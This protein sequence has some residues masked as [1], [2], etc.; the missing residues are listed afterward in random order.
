MKIL[1]ITTK[2]IIIFL[3][4]ANITSVFDTDNVRTITLTSSDMISGKIVGKYK[5]NQ[6]RKIVENAVGSLYANYSPHILQRNQF[7]DF[8]FTIYNKI[9]EVFY[10][11]VQIA[12]N[13]FARGKINADAGLFQFDFKSPLIGQPIACSCALI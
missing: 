6:I 11:E 8:D 1:L 3:K 7:L 10:P 13:T 5:V 12:E 4:N 9:L 2:K